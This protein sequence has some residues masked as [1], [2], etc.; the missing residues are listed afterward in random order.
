MAH[1]PYP[2]QEADIDTA[3][4]AQALA[5]RF[6]NARLTKAQCIQRIGGTAT[7]LRF[8]LEFAAASDA[9]GTLW[10]KSGVGSEGADQ[11]EAFINEVR[12]YNEM[13]PL[14]D[15]NM[16]DVYYAAAN[17]DAKNGVIVMEDLLHRNV[18]FGKSS[19]PL[20]V[21]Q[22][23][24]VLAMQAKF[25]ARFWRDET[26]SAR[27]WLKPG[28]SI[29]GSGMVGQYFAAFWERSLDLPRFQYVQGP[30]LRNRDRMR[31][32]LTAMIDEDVRDPLCLVHGDSHC[33]NLFFDPDGSPGYLDWQ[34]VMRGSWA[35]DVANLIVTGL[36]V[37]DRR[38][39]DRSLLEGYRAKLIEFGAAAASMEEMWRAYSRHALWSFMWAMCPVS[40]H[41]EEICTLNTERTCAAILDLDSANAL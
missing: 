20:S 27:A 5:A 15:V 2:H 18:T 36:D 31:D 22:A 30:L 41:P 7:K 26:L 9:P 11:G 24:A 13:A 34:H 3:W 37:A 33:A 19:T 39:H 40:A 1:V 32:L 14:L 29:A 4:L 38:A 10:V 6:P 17:E 25:H 28:G 35:F 8:Q 21:A 16:P 12:F 23:R